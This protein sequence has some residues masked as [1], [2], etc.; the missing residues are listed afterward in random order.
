[1]N[2]VSEIPDDDVLRVLGYKPHCNVPEIA[3]IA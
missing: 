2:V 3:R 1:M